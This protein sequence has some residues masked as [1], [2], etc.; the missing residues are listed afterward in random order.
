M[1]LGALDAVVHSP[2]NAKLAAFAAA[3]AC[4]ATFASPVTARAYEGAQSTI[5]HAVDESITPLMAKNG[6]PGMAVAVTLAGKSY[7]FTY[8][9]ASKQT[10]KP[11]TRDTLF[12][13]GS[14]SKTFTATL[15]SWAQ[16]RGYLLLSDPVEKYVPSLQGSE[17]GRVRLVDLGTHTPGGLP[18]QFPGDVKTDQ[19]M[20]AYFRS[21]HATYAPGTYRTYANP[22]IG[23][24]GF[25]TAKSAH[26]D[27]ATLMERELF[28]AL[29]LRNT[30]INVPP[31]RM[32]DYAQGYSEENAPARMKPG[33]LWQEAY[34]V[35]T[36]ASDLS[37]FLEANMSE[38]ALDAKLQGAIAQTHTGYFTA[39][40]L[41]QDLIWEQYAY[42]VTLRTL[43]DGNSPAMLLKPVPAKAIEP[44]EAPVTGAWLNKTGSTRGFSAYV[45]FV[46]AK[47]AGIVILANKSYPIADRV[48][49]AYAILTKL[50]ESR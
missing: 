15:A 23:M 25:V 17:F 9:I 35:R 2:M 22:G 10:G 20:L 38:I 37:R 41:T 27:F 33:V 31:N 11:V 47:R 40:P 32:P 13:I 12:E 8:G 26:R 3:I 48:T 46:P 5:R 6:I 36:T 49:T 42:P 4:T 14:V 7:V 34:G 21:W 50:M 39:G 16:A 18:L 24:L 28:P 44:A 1:Q 45:A 29:G 43:L 19:Q 30:Y